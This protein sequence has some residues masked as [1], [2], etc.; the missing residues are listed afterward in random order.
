MA[1]SSST[2]LATTSGTEIRERSL[3]R[4]PPGI[5]VKWFQRKET[6]T[7]DIEVPDIED[8]EVAM[9][10]EGFVELTSKSPKHACTLQLLRRIHTEQSR[11]FHSGRTIKLELAKAENGLGHWDKLCVGDKLPNI[12]IDWTS[13]MD[14]AEENEIRNNPYGH[15]VHHMAGAMGEHW[16]S[17]VERSMKAK[18]Q[19][20]A[21]DTSK[22][23]DPEDDIAMF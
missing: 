16:G 9:S 6:L 5:R 14:E 18:K 1:E 20:A 10:D 19:A 2:A 11:W 12:L 17:N 4:V 3:T 15:D 22:G 8:P 13:W 21:V 7:I 23:D